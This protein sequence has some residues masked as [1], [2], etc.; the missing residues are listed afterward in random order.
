MPHR[1]SEPLSRRL[2]LFSPLALLAAPRLAAAQTG[3]GQAAT[4]PDRAVR[5]I[6]P[7]TPGGAADIAARLM[8]ERLTPLWKQPVV[9]ENRAGG[10]GIVGTEV[11]AKSP[12]DGLNLACVSVVHAVNVALYNTPYDALDDFTVVTVI[13]SVPLVMVAAP[14]FPA[15][16]PA[17]AAALMKRE[18]ARANFAGTGGTVHLAGAMF[19][20]RTKQDIEHVPY[21]GSTAAHPDLM[22][23][24]VSVMFDTL[25]AVLGHVQSGKLKA[26]AVTSPARLPTLPS[27]PTMIESGFDG[28]EASTWGAILGPKGMPAP[29][30][31]K[32]AADTRAVFADD[33][34]HARLDALGATAVC[35]PPTEATAFVRS[36]ISKWSAVAKQAGIERQ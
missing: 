16:T 21:R 30:V 9:V 6:V 34:M 2:T 29:V 25:P 8:G 22:A 4:W 35:N 32:I 12:P 23:G 13:Y 27:V 20:A 28:F 17:E 19:A 3:A 24:R 10:N 5:I 31:D 11:V 14:D 26:L 15:N 36:E 7:Y 33:A 18:P 1:P